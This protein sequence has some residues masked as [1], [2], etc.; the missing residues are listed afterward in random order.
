MKDDIRNIIN[1]EKIRGIGSSMSINTQLPSQNSIV[2]LIPLEYTEYGL[3]V[4]I[5]G[6]LFIAFI[7]GKITLKE[8]IIA[9][10]TSSNPFSLSLNLLEILKKDEKLLVNQVLNKFEL[11]QKQSFRKIIPKIVLED[12]NLIKSKILLLD[13]LMHYF[14]AD[15]LEFSLLVDLIWSSSNFSKDMIND[16][17]ENLFDEP[18]EEVCLNLFA[19]IKSLLFSEIPQYFVQKINS[20]LI[21]YPESEKSFTITK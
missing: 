4:L 5:D 16:L 17:Y 21:Y 6:K 11:P 10:V 15:G 3:K 2:K 14:K 12:K 9:V 8:E 13:E 20:T 7:E 19:S 1:L 18:F